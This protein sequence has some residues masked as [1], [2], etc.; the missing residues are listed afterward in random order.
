MP[1]IIVEQQFHYNAKMT[2]N[3]HFPN[4]IYANCYAKL[5]NFFAC[6]GRQSLLHSQNFCGGE[7]FH[8]FGHCKNIKYL[9]NSYYQK[10]G[11][12]HKPFQDANK[13][14]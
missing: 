3:K 6:S 12:F 14:K 5:E 13:K 11:F 9:L 10:I 1:Q 2:S 8:Y 7:S 4:A